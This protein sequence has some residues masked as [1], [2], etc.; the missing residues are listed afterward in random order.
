MARSGLLL[1]A[2]LAG[3]FMPVGAEAGPQEENTAIA[4]IEAS[5]VR[6]PFRTP[7]QIA[8]FEVTQRQWRALMAGDPERYRSVHQGC[9]DCAVAHVSW[10]DA[11]QFVKRLNEKTSGGFRLPT[12]EEWEF[13]CQAGANHRHCGSDDIEEIG[14]IRDNSGD[15]V[16][17]V[18]LKKPNAWG[19]Y[20]MSGN[21]FEWTS[22]CVEGD[23]QSC[24]TAVMKGGAAD[25]TYHCA[26]NETRSRVVTISR[27]VIDGFRLARQIP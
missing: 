6:V 16:H 10:E 24:E 25:G 27:A 2:F 19:L 3:L 8:R 15:R 22:D 23:F 18:G 21:V 7:L 17:P 13:A 5:M 9:D 1:A 14:W 4:M 20:D 12:A 26:L 11:K